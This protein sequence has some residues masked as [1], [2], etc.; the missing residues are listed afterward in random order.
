MNM[1]YNGAAQGTGTRMLRRIAF[2]F[3]GLIVVPVLSV[4]GFSF[5]V[6]GVGL[7]VLSVLNLIGITSIP[8]NILFMQITGVQ[9]LIVALL[10]GALFI[11]LANRARTGLKRFFSI[12]RQCI[13]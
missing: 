7:P 6:I 12:Q 2:C 11:G 10:L 1:G 4:L 3:A 8:F 5:V 9:Q 13:R